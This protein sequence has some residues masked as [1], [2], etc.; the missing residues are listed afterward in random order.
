MKHCW[1]YLLSAAVEKTKFS[2]YVPRAV[3]KERQTVVKGAQILTLSRYYDLPRFVHN[4][5]ESLP[6]HRSCREALA[7]PSPTGQGW[8]DYESSRGI[9]EAPVATPTLTGA[10]PS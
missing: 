6:F 1:N 2:E 5:M 8:R 9:D 7:K 3:P 10:C 4:G